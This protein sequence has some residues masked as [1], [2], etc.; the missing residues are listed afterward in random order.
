MTKIAGWATVIG[1]VALSLG[2]CSGEKAPDDHEDGDSGLSENDLPESDGDLE[3]ESEPEE[4]EIEAE[5]ESREVDSRVLDAYLPAQMEKAHLP[6]LAVSVMK[7]D[8]L[9]WVK[10]YGW[11]DLKTEK[12]V[13]PDTLFMLASVS[14]TLIV[15]AVMQ[16]VE[17]GQ[18]DLDAEIDAYLPFTVR[19]PGHLQTPLTLRMLLTHASGIRD[20]WPT[21]R[22]LYVNGDSPIALGDFLEDYLTTGGVYYQEEENFYPAAPGTEHHYSNI[23]A[24]LA[25]YIVERVA[26]TT[27]EADSQEKILTP[28]G[29]ETAKWHL[30]DLDL[31]RLATSYMYDGKTRTYEPLEPYGYPDYPDGALRA[32]AAELSRFLMAYINRGEYGGVRIL[33]EASVEEILRIQNPALDDQQGLIWNYYIPTTG[34]NWGHA[35]NDDGVTTAMYVRASD[36]TGVILL[37]NGDTA[38]N[39]AGAIYFAEMMAK[40]FDEADGLCSE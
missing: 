40:V 17:A 24:T 27:F 12:P 18:L 7:G 23:G 11:A 15:T 8:R 30:R 22:S 16:R 35:G 39:I 3:R 19:N 6:G 25:A 37:S 5:D 10:G 4:A 9:C 36:G 26:E 31:T 2:G 34:E 28:L 14:K 38:E 21:I 13:T 1:L 33:T 20:N 29:M 32:S